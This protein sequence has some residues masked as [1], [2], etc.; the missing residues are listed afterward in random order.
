V[1]VERVDELLVLEVFL[2]ELTENGIE[3]EF[4]AGNGVLEFE[5][6]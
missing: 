1:R 2:S 3:V 4:E 5:G 6:I